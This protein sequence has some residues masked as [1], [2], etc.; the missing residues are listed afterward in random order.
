MYQ[1]HDLVQIS[2]SIQFSKDD[3]A[4]IWQYNSTGRYLVQSLYAIINNRGREG[5]GGDQVG[6]HTFSVENPSPS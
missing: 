5:G 3:D 1:W 6:L 2:Y 4:I